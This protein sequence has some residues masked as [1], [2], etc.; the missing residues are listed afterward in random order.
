MKFKSAVIFGVLCAA[1]MAAMAQ[2]SWQWI[3]KEGRK[4]YSDRPPPL[5]TPEKNILKQPAARPA[6]VGQQPATPSPASAA[7]TPAS[8]AAAPAAT[9]LRP[10]GKDKGLEE[11]KK[12]AEQ[13]EAALKQAEEEKALKVKAENCSRARQAKA[14][15]D[16]GVRI[17]RT[18]EKGERVV[19]DDAA[20]A[21]ENKRMQDI[22][23]SE[24]K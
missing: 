23:A 8:A 22:I 21:A 10:S 7:P 24:C 12:Q 11:K 4:V 13:E 9:A 2:W 3:D 19:L 15:L 18:N 16:S 20:R 1:S 5:D 6:P 17:A 14:G